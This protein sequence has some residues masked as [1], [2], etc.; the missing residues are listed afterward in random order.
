MIKESITPVSK[1][2]YFYYLRATGLFAVIWACIYSLNIFLSRDLVHYRHHFELAKS[3]NISDYLQSLDWFK[4]PTY[5]V[6][7]AISGK[8]MAFEIFVGLLVA[9]CLGLKWGALSKLIPKP[10]FLIVFPYLTILGFL[11]EGTQLRIALALSVALWSLVYWSKNAYGKSVLFLVIA[12]LFHISALSFLAIYLFIWLKERLGKPFYIFC[13]LLAVALA[14]PGVADYLILMWGKFVNARYMAYSQGAIYRT[15]NATG[16]FHYYFLFVAF[17]MLVIF[18]YCGAT[19]PT[20]H[21]FNQLSIICGIAGVSALID[22]RFNSV[23][24]SRIADLLLLP[25]TIA[26]GMSLVALKSHQKKICLLLIA[27][28]I[29]Y[30]MARGYTTFSYRPPSP[31]PSIQ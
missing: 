17:L 26:L 24:A 30:C 31:E 6:L 25:V 5:F 18:K 10:Q 28:F 21:R 20:T 12:G 7:Q 23:M 14:F 3:Q 29:A 8:V 1:K 4:D 9:I 22:L 2:D 13:L 16:L 11:H 27:I 15:L 19:N